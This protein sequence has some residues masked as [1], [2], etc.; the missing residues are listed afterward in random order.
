MECVG[1]IQ[2]RLGTSL[3]KSQ[4]DMKG[5]KLSD[6]EVILGKGRLTNK[7]INKNAESL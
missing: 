3:R 2:K 5:K 4:N 6:G 7:I 1:H